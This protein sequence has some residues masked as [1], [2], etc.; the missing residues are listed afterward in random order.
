VAYN[1]NF[2][3]F[4][5]NP[6]YT[7]TSFSDVTNP[8]YYNFNQPNVPNWSYP[9][10]YMPQSQYYKQDWNNHRYY[11]QG[12]RGYN[13]PESY[14]QLPYQHP[15]SYTPSPEQ[16]LEESIDW[17]KR[18]E[19]LDELERRI[20]ILEDSKSRQ[21]FQVTDLYSIFQE[22]HADLEKN[23]ELMIQSQNDP[24]DMREARL[25]R[26]MKN[27]RRNKETLPTQSL[28]IPDTSSHID[29]N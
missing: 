11:S 29:E 22:E 7:P 24:L 10:Q 13:S 8:T 25:S 9:N 18:M 15:A 14:C 23:M 21:N 4:N 28:T 19:A 17:K 16:P 27:M 12:Q 1:N 6:C 2:F 3:N 20:Q 26:L 5:G